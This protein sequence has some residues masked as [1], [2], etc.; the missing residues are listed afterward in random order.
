MVTVVIGRCLIIRMGDQSYFGLFWRQTLVALQGTVNTAATP[1]RPDLWLPPLPVVKAATGRVLWTF[2]GVDR[3]TTMMSGGRALHPEWATS[4][5]HPEA[6]QGWV[7]RRVRPQPPGYAGLNL[8]EWMAQGLTEPS[9]L[10]DPAVP[11]LTMGLPGNPTPGQFTGHT[12][13][14]DTRQT[15]TLWRHHAR[16]LWRHQPPIRG[17]SCHRIWRHLSHLWCHT[18]R[19]SAVCW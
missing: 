3:M 18:H 6:S 19:K 2:A 4:P 7:D 14:V 8:W 11:S 12:P 5:P 9:P 16:D 17:H 1:H 13:Y 10:P 15:Y